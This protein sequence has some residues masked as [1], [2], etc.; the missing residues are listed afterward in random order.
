MGRQVDYLVLKGPPK[1]LNIDNSMNRIFLIGESFT[2]FYTVD[3]S[4]SF[5]SKF[6]YVIRGSLNERLGAI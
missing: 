2:N 3:N 4:Y 1:T 5:I 6:A